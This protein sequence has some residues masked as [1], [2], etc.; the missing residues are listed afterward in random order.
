MADSKIT[1]ELNVQ[2][3]AEVRL[4]K[5][6]EAAEAATSK[7]KGSFGDAGRIFD[8]FIANIGST[9]AVKAFQTLGNAISG[10]VAF[11][12]ESA[13]EAAEAQQNVTNLEIALRSAG[14][15]SEQASR[16][17]Q[18]FA[19]AVQLST[20]YS[21][22][23]VLS[24]GALIE[25]MGKLSEEGLEQATQAALDLA[26]A[27]NIDLQSAARAVG[28]A[29]TGNISAL[30]RVMKTELKEGKDVAET[31]AL[32]LKK[33]NEAAGGSAAAQVNT[34]SGATAK[35]SNQFGEL[36]ESIGNIII[37]NPVLI[38]L[39]QQA[40]DGL[41]TATGWIVKNKDAIS[42]LV[43]GGLVL[44]IK[45]VEASV[46]ALQI[47]GTGWLKVQEATYE[48]LRAISQFTKYVPGVI[49]D[50]A[51]LQSAIADKALP[52]IRAGLDGLAGPTEKFR[53]TLTATIAT[54][55]QAASDQESAVIRGTQASVIAIDQVITKQGE[56]SEKNMR[57][58][59]QEKSRREQLASDNIAILQNENI[60]LAQEDQ[61]R[62]ETAIAAN[63]ALI[64]EQLKSEDI[65]SK[66]RSDIQRGEYEF[67]N[68][69]QLKKRQDQ[70]ST[71]NYISTLQTAKSKEL[72]AIGKAAAVTTATIDGFL[73]VQRALASFPPPF[74]FIA[75]GLVGAATAANVAGIVGIP[76]AKGITEVP[77]GFSNDNFPARLM[78]GERVVDANANQDLK[79]F[80]GPS[81][82]ERAIN[83][84]IARIDKLETNVTV[85]V[86]SRVIID[87]VRDGIRAG[88]VVNV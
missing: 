30:G 51:R 32:A 5:I 40:T 23:A 38:K 70:L 79:S 16:D 67:S 63:Q 56:L 20:K 53:E 11:I 2:G 65:G 8:N 82:F 12:K 1:I 33:I 46:I 55:E 59:E 88:R 36:K 81:G 50:I 78:S 7:A 26:S 84:L 68:Q 49:G 44:L 24:A 3:D 45:G 41:I 27:Y 18:E 15:T 76:L 42:S 86:G 9:I 87:E 13:A 28:A 77:P 71:L 54:L 35:L 64:A 74:N 10:A 37:T 85:Y 48:T 52:K 43:S 6:G 39:I 47:F 61:Y 19:A 14:I 17:F 60:A 58:A 62:N 57:A 66:K 73:A 4:K 31:F 22:D 83:T 34:Y 69:L 75:A 29:A 25:Q 72:Q 21:D 80:L